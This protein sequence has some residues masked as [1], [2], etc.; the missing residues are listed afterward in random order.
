MN[1]KWEN[2][3][4][5]WS[6]GPSKSEQERCDNTIRA[7]RTA[8]GK[9]EKLS[10]KSLKVF[11]QG[12]YRNNV[13]VTQSS[14]VDVGVIC[15]DIFYAEY[16]EG[17][18]REDYGNMVGGYNISEFRVDLFNAMQAHFPQNSVELGS[19]AIS[20][21]SNSY[22]V[23]A[24]VVPLVEFRRY[25]D[26]GAY[27]AG[28]VLFDTKKN[29]RIQNYPEI[30]FPYW[31]QTPLHY[32]NGVSKNARCSRRFKGVV[33]IL[34]NLSVAMTNDGYTSADNVPSYLLECITY[35][36]P[37]SIFSLSTWSERVV[38][39]LDFVE[40]NAGDQWTEV[41]E[42]KYLFHSSQPWKLGDVKEFIR[43]VRSCLG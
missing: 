32:E 40:A 5:T 31:P 34:K 35:N 36:C 33:R 16:P 8:I 39:V 9:S 21:N 11:I 6:T 25:W 14:D 37:D 2:I 23:D 12:S 3:F 29:V 13:N 42:I 24:D 20:V 22:R 19:K 41:D 7:V 27:R 18:T 17:K 38:S 15:N 1:V 10:T 4:A 26:T 28:V 43:D 30:L